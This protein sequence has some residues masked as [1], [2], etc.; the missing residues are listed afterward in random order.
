MI[1]HTLL[2]TLA[3]R[4][5][6]CFLI[7]LFLLLANPVKTTIAYASKPIYQWLKAESVKLKTRR[8][9]MKNCIAAWRMHWQSSESAVRTIVVSDEHTLASSIPYDF[10]SDGFE[11]CLQY[12]KEIDFNKHTLLGIYILTGSCGELR[13]L[14]QVLKDKVRK[15]YRFVVSYALPYAHCA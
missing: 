15:Q 13:S 10:K 8:F 14:Y 12:L 1:M 2:S 3:S 4:L 9:D 5:L 11:E 7:V 6:S